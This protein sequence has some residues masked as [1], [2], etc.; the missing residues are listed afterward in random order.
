[1]ELS[2]RMIFIRKH[3]GLSQTI[4]AESLGLKQGSYSDIERGRVKTLSE[5]VIRLLQLNYNINKDWI[6]GESEMM[7][8]PKKEPV[9][10]EEKS[11]RRNLDEFITTAPL[12]SQYAYAGY[13]SGYA[14]IEY[15]GQQPQYLAA[16]KFSNGNYVAF[17]IRGDSMEDGQR[18]AIYNSDIVLGRELVRDYWKSKIHFPKTFVIVHRTKGIICK[19]IISHDV[20]NGIITCHSFNPE[21]E[22]FELNLRDVVQ[23]FYVKEIKREP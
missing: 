16:K 17:E 7:S 1:V 3:L 18:H 14:D 20:E 13:L 2:E 23:L 21:Y 12:I 19:E 9:K 6:T 8:T 10:K 4:F 5:S 22:D 11:S 15:I